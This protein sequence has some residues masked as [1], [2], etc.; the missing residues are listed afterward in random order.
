MKLYLKPGACSFSSHLVLEESGLAYD[1]EVVDLA[2]KRTAS[3]VDFYTVNP[4]GYVPA[5][6]LDSGDLLT[7]GPAIVQYI[8]DLVPHKALA[9]ANGTLA[10]YQVQGWLTFIGTELHR[11]HSAFFNPTA[12]D[13]WKNASRANLERRLAYVEAHFADGRAYLMGEAF[14]VADA[15]LFT[16]LRWMPVT[17]LDPSRWPHLQAFKARMALRPAVQAVLQ[18]EGLAA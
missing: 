18:A 13:D 2:T 15:Y 14:C 10:R 7:E 4:K 3:G 6:V 1:T 17:G 8:A 16:V 11:N 12:K 9:P 5:L